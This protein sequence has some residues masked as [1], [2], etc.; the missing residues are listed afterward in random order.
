MTRIDNR[1]N[2]QLRN[3]KITRNYTKYAEG[4]VLI[5]IGETKVICTASI[6]DKVPPFLRH[7]GTGWINAEYSMLPRSTHQRKVRESSRGKIDG[8]T[9]EIQR[10]IGRAIRSVIDLDKIGERTIWVDCDVIQADGGTRTASI[11][12]AFVAVVDALNKLHKSK[13]IKEMPVRNF[14]SAISVGIV[15]NQYLL[16]LCYE[17][18]SKAHVDMNIIMTDKCE[19]VEVQGTGEERPFSRKDLN[20][21]LELGEKGNKELIKAQRE[22][23]GEIADEI[24][25]MEYGDEVVIATNNAH[26]LEEIGAILEDFDYK[27][28][29]LK[30]VNLGGIE[31]VEDGKTFE[32]NALIKARTIA[33]LTNKIAISD[34]SGLEVDAIGKKP[35]IYSAR[36]AGENATDEQNREKLL[37]A[38]ANTPMSKRT[39]RFVSAIAVVFPDGKEFVVRGTCEGYIGFEEKGKNGF[40]YD[41]LFIVDGY[42]KTFGEIPSAV[43]N[44]ISH[45]ANALKLMKSEFSK[46]VVR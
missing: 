17:E 26:K 3:I 45:R 15:N 20:T 46:R 19:F 39:A 1:N 43:K 35:G 16:D 8:R 37:K 10:L 23:L 22:A 38:L 40:G 32:H 12:G 24:L 30:D 14:V 25:G 5:E 4:S 27:I 28:Y 44:S 33:K 6:E 31:I 18:D 2:D 42:N 11:T 21:L 36:Y 34:D 13:A 9:Q 41:S 7:T 29:S